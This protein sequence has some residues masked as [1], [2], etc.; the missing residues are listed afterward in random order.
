[1][2]AIIL[3]AGISGVALAHFLQK[4]K[5]NSVSFSDWKL[6]DEYEVNEGQKEGRPRKKIDTIEEMLELTQSF[7]QD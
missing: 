3:G 1:M 2:K 4:K 5:I 7:R 6:L